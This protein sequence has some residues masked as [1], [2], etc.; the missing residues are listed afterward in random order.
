MARARSAGPTLLT[1]R[2]T[3]KQEIITWYEGLLEQAT[4]PAGLRWEPIKVG[5]TWQYGDDGWCLPQWTLGWD[6]LAWCGMWLRGKRGPWAFT[7]EQAR[8]ILWFYALDEQGQFD[9]HSAVLQRMKGWGKD[10]VAATLGVGSMFADVNFDH[11]DGDRPVGREEPNAWVQ[12]VA[13]SQEQTKNTMKLMPGLI[14]AETRRHYGIQVGKTSVWGLGDT[15]Q[16]EAVTNSVMAIEGGRP[17]L[18]VRNETQNWNSSNGGHD[19]AGALEGNAAKRDLDSP[20]RMLDICNAYRPGED[21]VGQRVREAWEATLGD[22]GADDEDDRPAALAFG[23]MYDSLEAPPEAPLTAEAAPEVVE[24]VRGDAVWLDAKGR[25][26]KSILNTANPPS[27]SRRKW[28]NQVTAAEDAYTTPQ[29]W[30]PGSRPDEKLD[31]GDEV[32]LTLDCSKSDDA[33]GLIATR[34]TDGFAHVLGMWQKPPG[35]RGEGWLAPRE[36]VDA[37]VTAAM[38]SLN[39][40][41]FFGDPSHVLDD[42]SL[43]RYWDN[44]FDQWHRRYK[45]KLRLWAKPGKDSGHA[46]MFDMALFDNQKRFVEAVQIAEADLEAGTVLHD[47]DARLR[48]HVLNARRQPTKAGMSIAKEHRESKAKIDLAVVWV[49]GRMARRIYLNTRT[50]KGGRIW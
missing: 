1:S 2:E 10:P 23:L 33:T 48:T 11:W 5:P 29:L 46:V 14:P 30:D 37:A 22:A 34:V 43:E 39:V 40:V 19:M 17:T 32:V 16:T 20:A 15:R 36:K 47:G 8:F 35:K 24:A 21:S 41:A 13:V 6:F 27:E 28:Y 38:E 26:L 9:F 45:H 18:V 7:A 3:E 4:P 25:I 44:L 49:L 42:E 12:L 50:K 31:P